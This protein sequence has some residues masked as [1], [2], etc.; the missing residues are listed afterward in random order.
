MNCPSTTHCCSPPPL[1][2]L[3]TTCVALGATSATPNR[4]TS[5]PPTN[6]PAK[7]TPSLLDEDPEVSSPDCADFPPPPEPMV[8]LT[9]ESQEHPRLTLGQKTLSG[10][11]ISSGPGGHFETYEGTE[12]LQVEDSD[13]GLDRSCWVKSRDEARSGR[14]HCMSRVENDLLLDFLSNSNTQAGKYYVLV[15]DTKL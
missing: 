9:S 3:T 4:K 11:V 15:Y 1:M 5:L 12:T 6:L 7:T 14:R 8:A 2:T 10:V 13:T